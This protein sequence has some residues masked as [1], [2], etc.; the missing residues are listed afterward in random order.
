MSGGANDV[1]RQKV[2]AGKRAPRVQQSVAQFHAERSDAKNVKAPTHRKQGRDIVAFEAVPCL[3]ACASLCGQPSLLAM[4]HMR[5]LYGQ[6]GHESTDCT[7]CGS[8]VSVG[9][10]PGPSTCARNKDAGKREG[11]TPT[12]CVT[13]RQR[14][15]EEGN[16]VLL[17]SYVV[18]VCDGKGWW[19]HA[20][21]LIWSCSKHEIFEKNVCCSIA[22]RSEVL[23][24]KGPSSS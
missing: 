7:V 1:K 20:D 22:S 6:R 21:G 8:V 10:E 2:L 4:T 3:A 11:K 19:W 14:E 24:K 15:R 16:A 23:K 9:C 5:W 18:A 12:P 13:D 17:L